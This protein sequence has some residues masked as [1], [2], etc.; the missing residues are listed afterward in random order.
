MIFLIKFKFNKHLKQKFTK[1]LKLAKKTSKRLN[2]IL[3]IKHKMK[4]PFNQT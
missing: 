4:Y 1:H 3:E 2:F